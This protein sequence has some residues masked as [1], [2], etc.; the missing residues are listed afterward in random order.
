MSK[1]GLETQCSVRREKDDDEQG[2]EV[3]FMS[4]R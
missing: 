3:E 2:L 1:S 4:D